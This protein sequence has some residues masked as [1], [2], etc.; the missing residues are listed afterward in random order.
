MNYDAPM[1]KS[2]HSI[3]LIFLLCSISIP[4]AGHI[5]GKHSFDFLNV[6][7]SSYPQKPFIVGIVVK[8]VGFV[9]TN[10][11]EDSDSNSLF[12]IQVDAAL[13][14]KHM[15]LRFSLTAYNLTQFHISYVNKDIGTEGSET[16]SKVTAYLNLASEILN[17]G[18]MPIMAG[19]DYV[20]HQALKL[21]GGGEEQAYHWAF[22][23]MLSLLNLFLVGRHMSLEVPVIPLL[24]QQIQNKL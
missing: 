3:R 19:C 22:Q 18:N 10:Y 7:P 6:A 12:D 13:K 16:L 8:D 4:V 11:W 5:G 17:P 9:L 14:P 2:V 1:L 21:T 20:T 23:R 15:P 24:C